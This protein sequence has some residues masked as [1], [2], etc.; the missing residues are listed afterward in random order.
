[1]FQLCNVGKTYR[2]DGL[3]CTALEGINLSIKRGEFFGIIGRSGAG[4][5]T[6]LRC[7]NLLEQP[8]G[9]I[10]LDNQE[11]TTLS[12]KQLRC[13][14]RK[15]GKIFQHFNL[16]QTQ[17]ASGNIAL[18]L[19]LAGESKENITQRVSELLTLVEL[20]DKADVYPDQLSGG[21]KQRVAIARALATRPTILLCDE[22]TSALDTETASKILNLLKSIQHQTGVTIILVSHQL[23]L[24][25]RYCDRV[26]VIADGQCQKIGS[27]Q[28][29]L[30]QKEH[31][32]EQ[33]GT[34]CAS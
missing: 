14:R 31:L 21:Q 29:V 13:I 11:L 1:M 8:T 17:T 28:T 3:L 19:E 10:T 9:S 20:T 25:K 33:G 22:P 15:I 4:K 16:L 5:S 18:P 12:S 7:I 32:I 24:I 30:A 34:S 27:P 2:Q 26:A 6:L 23:D